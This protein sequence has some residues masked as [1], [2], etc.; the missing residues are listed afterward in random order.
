M[1]WTNPLEK[2]AVLD[3]PVVEV[4]PVIWQGRLVLAECWRKEWRN[5]PPD[6]PC[7][8]IRD[9]ASDA[10]V[11]H[12]FPGYSL[13]SAFVWEDTFYLFGAQLRKVGDRETWHNVSMASSKDLE[14]WTPP[15]VVVKQNP[16]ENCFNQSVCHDGH[17]FVM[18]YETNALVPFTIKF[19][20]S[21]DL[22]HW[23]KVP[24]AIFGP[25]RYAACPAIRFTGG[26]FYMLY[27]E[28]PT[29]D[30]WFETWVARSRD[31]V[32]WELSPHNPV[33]APD[34]DLDV[35]P[36]CPERV[37]EINASD[38]DLVEWEGRTRVY[39]TGGHQHHSGR[40]QYAEFDGP[41]RAFFER[42][43]ET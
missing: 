19:A 37:K 25:D 10:A 31:L 16:D 22:V 26:W 2:K 20:E 41:E 9:V 34:P 8:L 7:V 33:I 4:T 3:S 14:T 28:R 6:T 24:D 36:D 13:A 32:D 35:H 39:F 29:E 40:L 17:R 12:G 43:F 18:A 11:G 23:R 15:K 1:T 30:W 5:A 38:P 27:L 21:N 42:Y